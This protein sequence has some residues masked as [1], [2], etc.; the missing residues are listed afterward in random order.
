MPL[1]EK[2]IATRQFISL[3]EQGYFVQRISIEKRASL[4]IQGTRV[5]L[6][7]LSS[8]LLIIIFGSLAIVHAEISD[9]LWAAPLAAPLHDVN[10]GCV[11]LIQAG[12]FEQF[13]PAWQIQVGSRPPAYS[14]EQTFN[15]STYALRIGNGL[16][17]PDVESVSEVR[18]APIALPFGAT[19]LILRFVYWPL[20]E[21]PVNVND[22]QQ[23][24]LF[25]AT[26][27]QLIAPLLTVQD[28]ARIWKAVDYDLTAYAGRQV[29]LRFRVRND[30]Q[31]GRALMYIDNVEI[32]YCAATA[33]PTHTPSQVPSG[34]S[35]PTATGL[36]AATV[37]PT[38]PVVIITPSPA[39]PTA[40]PACTNIL[41]DPGFEGWN[42]WQFGDDP[43]PGLYVAEPRYA[44]ARAV[45]LGNPPNQP[46]NVVTFSSVRQLVTVPANITR[47]ELRWRKLLQTTQ[48]GAPG[49][50]SDRQDL[51]LLSP[52]L[53][54]IQ[55]LRRELS[56][57]G[58]WQE[59]LVDITAYRG[60]SFY[61]YF[62]AFNDGNGART[63]MYLDDV[64]LNICGVGTTGLYSNNN[65]V[66]AT[67]IA[68][69]LTSIATFTEAPIPTPSPLST[70]IVLPN[71]TVPI[72]STVTIVAPAALPI[73]PPTATP[74]VPLAETV[75]PIEI[76]SPT[77]NVNALATLPTSMAISTETPDTIMAPDA[78]VATAQPP[79]AIIATPA[80]AQPVWLDRL[81]PISVLVGI[82]VLIGF[83]VWAILRTFRNS[84]TP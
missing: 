3:W 60:Q 46:T 67:P 40:D 52:T 35:I 68:I 12:N 71:A 78:S 50:L 31:P 82:L 26:T 16:E 84:S 55:I 59:D 20:H 19:S 47:A 37:T 32:E 73:M 14:T 79:I 63:W 6:R 77:S 74:T 58:I 5:Y 4:N 9:P 1:S 81:G 83:I 70:P 10:V 41:G 21:A 42:G 80:A 25:D 75:A 65:F 54:P 30:G 36:P 23:V 43:V 29:S 34:T 17:L 53:Q 11:D 7:L 13:N 38:P 69:P 48:G 51:I 15:G 62:N 44:G 22:L 28:D 18:H 24:D 45:Q 72:S 8:L 76:V 64:Q 66:I 33:I 56:N 61:I 49:S 27:D 39:L 57:V 2:A